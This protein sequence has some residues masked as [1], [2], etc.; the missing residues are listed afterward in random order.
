MNNDYFCSIYTLVAAQ[1]KRAE[2]QVALEV[3][4][5]I[6]SE[7]KMVIKHRNWPILQEGQ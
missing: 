5:Q 7:L 1:E 3:K 6:T 2:L 4:T